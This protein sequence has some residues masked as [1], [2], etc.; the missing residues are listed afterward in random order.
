MLIFLEKTNGAVD[1]EQSS[2]IYTMSREE[3]ESRIYRAGES[4]R[5]LQKTQQLDKY[6]G[7]I[8][9]HKIIYETES[10]GCE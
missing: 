4:E 8:T 1:K 7:V 6:L 10:S 3:K 5:Y 9:F 2:D